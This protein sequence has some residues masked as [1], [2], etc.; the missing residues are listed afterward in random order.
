MNSI[1]IN[2]EEKKM[3]IQKAVSL[4]AAMAFVGCSHGTMRGSVAMKT[5]DDE[6]HVCLGKG[7]VKVGDKVN[8]FENRCKAQGAGKSG[9]R[10]I[11][12]KVKV[13]E[14]RVAELLNEHYSVVQTTA[15]TKF[16]EGT[17]VERQ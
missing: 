7:E 11:C 4:L 9:A 5:S 16:T 3:K 14:G 1:F 12:D 2:Q 10:E 15:G 6:A 8:F 13:G 17:V